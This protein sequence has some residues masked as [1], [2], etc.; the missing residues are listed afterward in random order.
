M[1]AEKEAESGECQTRA[2]GSNQG[3]RVEGQGEANTVDLGRWQDWGDRKAVSQAPKPSMTAWSRVP[4]W[5][6]DTE[7]Q[8][9]N[10][11]NSMS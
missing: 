9:A 3:T 2:R 11:R 4:E 6:K 1:K 5:T 10:L 8:G 7:E